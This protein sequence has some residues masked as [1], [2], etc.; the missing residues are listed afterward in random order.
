MP[1]DIAVAE[2][3]ATPFE[4]ASVRSG[5]DRGNERLWQIVLQKSFC[6]VIKNSAG[7]RRGFRVKM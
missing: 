3:Y 1:N 5:N 6:T 2:R 4:V 7:R